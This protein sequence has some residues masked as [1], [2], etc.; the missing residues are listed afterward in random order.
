MKALKWIGILLGC[1]VGLVV[2]FEASIG[3]FQ[4]TYDGTLSLTVYDEDDQPQ[5]RVLSK[6]EH[7]GNV[8]VA[9]NHWPRS[10][11]NDLQANPTIKVAYNEVDFT[12]TAIVVDTATAEYARLDSDLAAPFVFRFL[13]GFPPRRFVRLEP[14]T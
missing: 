10:W 9:V 12:G 14:S 5:T 13:T 3:Y 7:S 6:I 11:F 8:Y 4:P 2:L 1:Y